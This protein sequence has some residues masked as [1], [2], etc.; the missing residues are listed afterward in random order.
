MNPIKTKEP[1][2]FW[3]EVL[4]IIFTPI[5]LPT[6]G[7]MILFMVSN[8]S[9]FPN[10]NKLLT[11]WIFFT[12]SLLLPAILI[13]LFTLYQGWTR[14]QLMEKERRTVPYALAIICYLF[15]YYMLC[16][17]QIIYH[18]KCV[19]ITALIILVACSLINQKTNVSTHSAAMGGTTG[20]LVIYSMQ[21]FQ[22]NPI[23]WL[24]LVIILSGV[25]GS[26]QII[27]RHHDLEQTLIGYGIGVMAAILSIL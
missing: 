27:L 1:L 25:I 20:L 12:F 17:Y 14:Q 11:I 23:W 22:F 7:V 6:L 16:R 19:I 21:H 2:T 13:T 8:F 5:I 10:E 4:N 24:C 15:C 18:I 9:L 3:A 26:C